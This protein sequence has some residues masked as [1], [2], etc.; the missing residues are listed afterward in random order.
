MRPRGPERPEEVIG[1][2]N[3]PITSETAVAY[4]D[5]LG[6]I[7]NARLRSLATASRPEV[8]TVAGWPGWHVR[9]GARP[10]PSYCFEDVSNRILRVKLAR[11]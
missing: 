5:I 2:S 9:L 7:E 10:C 4:D 6:A 1:W 8:T 3:S 11:N